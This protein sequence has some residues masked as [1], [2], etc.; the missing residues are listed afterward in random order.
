MALSQPL[1]DCIDRALKQE[2][3]NGEGRTTKQS[4]MLRAR[5]DARR[6]GLELEIKLAAENMIWLSN[7]ERRMKRGLPDNVVGLVFRNAP[8]ALV[9]AMKYLPKCIAVGEGPNAVW[10]DSLRATSEDWRANASLKN[11]KAE[12]T[13]TKAILSNDIARW[14]EEHEMISLSETI[15]V[16]EVDA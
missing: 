2:L 8:P 5:T 7:V 11:K 16:E 12:Q 4:V 3:K 15:E 10:V 9:Q 6:R 1:Q 13:F 14:M